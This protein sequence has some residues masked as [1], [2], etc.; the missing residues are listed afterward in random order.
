[1][2]QAWSELTR[3]GSY[4]PFSAVRGS[5]VRRWSDDPLR[6][7][8]T[9]GTEDVAW[10]VSLPTVPHAECGRR[11][12]GWPVRQPR[13]S[14]APRV[15]GLR[16]AYWLDLPREEWTVFH[17]LRW[18]GRRFAN[19]DHVV[20]GPPGV[21][22]IDTKN[23]SGSITVRENVLMQ[24]G[25]RREKAV[26]GAADAALAVAQLSSVV[27]PQHVF[28]VLCFVTPQPLT[29]H[30]R[31]VMVCSTANVLTM[32]N[33]RPRALSEDTRRRLCVDLEPSFCPAT[34]QA[35]RA[36]RPELQARP[37][38]F[39]AQTD[40]AHQDLPRVPSDEQ[41]VR[42]AHRLRGNRQRHDGDV[43]HGPAGPHRTIL[44]HGGVATP[45]TACAHPVRTGRTSEGKQTPGKPRRQQRDVRTT[46]IP[47]VQR[48]VLDMRSLLRGSRYSTTDTA[49]NHQA[50]RRR[51]ASPCRGPAAAGC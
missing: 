50:V 41:T 51:R 20:V 8:K 43:D 6:T 48:D 29:G 17:D 30:A 1:M 33:T 9:R 46:L 27:S 13:M 12:S 36:R 14:V 37:S 2:S 40:T 35:H 44:G 31:E 22:V 5:P 7:I 28:P 11:R 34:E 15:S 42:Q 26:V 19:V 3:C 4:G 16:P 21:F 47:G 38:E 18:P 39:N 32:L 10:L 45:A 25:R 23:W 49:L 24:N